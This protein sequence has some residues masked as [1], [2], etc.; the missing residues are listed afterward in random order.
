MLVW[1]EP[2]RLFL[3]FSVIAVAMSL[4][5]IVFSSIFAFVVHAVVIT[6]ARSL[7]GGH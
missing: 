5:L 3:V 1:Y 6:F 7:I 4:V 2:A